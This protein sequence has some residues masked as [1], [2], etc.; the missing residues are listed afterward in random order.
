M[1]AAT[2]K[3]LAP[4][5]KGDGDLFCHRC[6]KG[7]RPLFDRSAGADLTA[8]SPESGEPVKL[9]RF[10]LHQSL[11]SGGFGTVFLAT[12]TTLNRQVG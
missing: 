2:G 9:G 10:L 3:R 6:R 7:P 4:R 5:R 1:L 11:G 8:A 12:D